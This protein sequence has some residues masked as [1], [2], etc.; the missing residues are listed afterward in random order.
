MIAFICIFFGLFAIVAIILFIRGIIEACTFKKGRNPYNRI[1]K[2]CGSHQDMYQSNIEGNE[3]HI[4][5]EEV[6]PIGNDENCK[7]HKY[8]QYYP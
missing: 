3:N 8:A 2:K 1:C 4:W 7:C 6:Y 5:W